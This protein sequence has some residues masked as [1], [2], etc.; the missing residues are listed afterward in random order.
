MHRTET[1]HVHLNDADMD[2][3][4]ALYEEPIETILEDDDDRDVDGSLFGV[5]LTTYLDTLERVREL[6]ETLAWFRATIRRISPTL[7]E[8]YWEDALHTDD[9]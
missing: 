3:V 1:G 8:L 4:S 5:S 7:S 6:E 2:I 9:G